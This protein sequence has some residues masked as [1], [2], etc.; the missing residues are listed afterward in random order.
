MLGLAD[1]VGAMRRLAQRMVARD[2]M[3]AAREKKKEMG[4]TG[5]E[6]DEAF[7]K[8]VELGRYTRHS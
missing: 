3:R 4:L 7:L 1:E 5:A 2:N 6:S 8:S